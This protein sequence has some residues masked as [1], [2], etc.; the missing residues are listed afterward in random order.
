MQHTGRHHCSVMFVAQRGSTKREWRLKVG[1][2]GGLKHI[3]PV[4]GA[5]QWL[6]G[7]WAAS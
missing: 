5:E 2:R 6:G 3:N 7:D 4:R 1:L